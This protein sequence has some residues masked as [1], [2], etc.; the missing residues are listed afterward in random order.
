MSLLHDLPPRIA[1]RLLPGVIAKGS[2]GAVYLTFDDG[3]DPET[4][5]DFLRVLAELECQ[6]TFFLTGEKIPGNEQIVVE[7]LQGGHGLGAHGYHH[8][9]LLQANCNRLRIEVNSTLD[10]IEAAC[11][12]RPRL[13][14]PPY[15]RIAPSGCNEL[16]RLGLTTVLWS[17]SARDWKASSPALLASRI[18]D[19]TSDGNII[20]LHDSGKGAT[21]TLEA[22]PAII[23][24]IRAKGF[25]LAQLEDL[26]R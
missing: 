9:S 2:P 23:R 10:A 17:R 8:R 18:I 19:S 7:T 24:G 4:T 26:T 11:G 12:Q 25:R 5:P 3:P 20:L 15:G 13:F 22:L 6:A 16:Q 14:R 21:T 1:A